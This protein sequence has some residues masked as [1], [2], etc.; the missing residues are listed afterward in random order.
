[1]VALHVQYSLPASKQYSSPGTQQYFYY[2]LSCPEPDNILPA[3][4]LSIPATGTVA[5]AAS[6]VAAI[7]GPS[8]TPFCVIICTVHKWSAVFLANLVYCFVHGFSHVEIHNCP[9]RDLHSSY[10]TVTTRSMQKRILSKFLNWPLNTTC[11]L[12]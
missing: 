10:G 6:E 7:N 2:S 11:T 9:R 8:G 12:V 4:A 5:A 1:M 3:L